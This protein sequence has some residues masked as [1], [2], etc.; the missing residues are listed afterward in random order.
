[1]TEKEFFRLVPKTGWKLDS[2][3][4]MRRKIKGKEAEFCPVT[5]VAHRKLGTYYGP[6]AYD[7]AA[8]KMGFSL[9]RADEIAFAADCPSPAI[10]RE[11]ALRKKLLKHAN[12]TEVA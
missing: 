1:M 6:C 7:T 5:A 12:L 9:N 2:V 11:G 8:E 4:Q 10:P 3:G